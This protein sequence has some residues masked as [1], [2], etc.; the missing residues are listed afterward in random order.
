MLTFPLELNKNLLIWGNKKNKME[1]NEFTF[2]LTDKELDLILVGLG[3][4]TLEQSLFVYLKLRN[5]A[6]EQLEAKK[7]VKTEATS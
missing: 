4:L 2:T 5:G 1:Q 7:P 3:K 6:Q